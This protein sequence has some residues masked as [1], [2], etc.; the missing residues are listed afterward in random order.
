MP[1]QPSVTSETLSKKRFNE[2]DSLRAIACSLVIIFHSGV[3]SERLHKLFINTL[4]IGTL[5]VVTFFAISGFVI[6]GSL[7][8]SRVQGIRRFAIRRFW[9]LYPPFWIALLLTWWIDKWYKTARLPWDAIMLPTLGPFKNAFSHFWTLEIELFFYLSITALFFVLGSLGWRILLPSFLLFAILAMRLSLSSE[10]PSN[11]DQIPEYLAV[12]FWS[13]FCREILRLNSSRWLW[14][15]PRYG[16]NWAKACALGVS[17]AILIIP[18]LIK[19]IELAWL[20]SILGFLFWVVLTPVQITWM[21]YVGRWTYS[22]YLFHNLII[23]FARSQINIPF[24]REIS[25]IPLCFSGAC[26]LL[27]FSVG[28]LAYRWIEKP[29]EAPQ[30]GHF[31]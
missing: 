29:R 5:G 16:I 30:N 15:S 10:S 17:T 21:S 12:M 2:I 13:G 27:S 7:K 25:Q 14:L 28:A 18:H 4:G 1:L 26:L 11:Y 19:G 3:S 20:V 24:F 31:W 22:T 23:G 6:P 8:G 9:R